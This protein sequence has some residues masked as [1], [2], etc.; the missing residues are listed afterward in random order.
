MKDVLKILSMLLD[1][2]ISLDSDISKDN[3]ELWDSMKQIEIISTLEDELDISFNIEDIP[4]LT[5]V[6]KILKAIKELETK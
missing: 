3:Y 4:K 2:E 6:K 5:S 1:K